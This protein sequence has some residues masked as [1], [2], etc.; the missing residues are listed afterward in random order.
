MANVIKYLR[1]EV[2]TGELPEY[3]AVLDAF[4]A[5]DGLLGEYQ[6]RDLTNMAKDLMSQS[7]GLLQEF[8]LHLVEQMPS[9]PR[10]DEAEVVH[11]L[12]G[13]ARSS[14]HLGDR[15]L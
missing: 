9:I 15:I 8:G 13:I 3:Q 2:K 5:Q 1:D 6:N 12:I 14:P 11:V 7:E 10:D 4:L